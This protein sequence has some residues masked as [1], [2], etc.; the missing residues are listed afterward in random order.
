MKRLQRLFAVVV[1]MALALSMAISVSAEGE[2]NGK[3]TVTGATEGQVYTLYQIATLES[4]TAINYSYKITD[5][6]WEAFLEQDPYN[7]EVTNG[8]IRYDGQS[9]ANSELPGFALAA[10]EYAKANGIAATAS[11]TANSDSVVFENLA[12][13]YYAVDSSLGTICMLTTANPEI[14]IGDKNATTTVNKFVKEDSNGTYDKSNDASIGQ[15]VEFLI[16][17]DVALGAINYVI[18]DEMSDGLTC[19]TVSKI[20]YILNETEHLV[21]YEIVYATEGA[22]AV[23]EALNSFFGEG[24]YDAAKFEN[25]DFVL[26]LDNADLVPG[27]QIEIIYTATVNE[28]A[29]IAGTGN[30]N[31]VTLYYGENPYVES[32]KSTTTTF[33]W[34]F[35]VFKYAAAT[36][37]ELPLEGAVFQLYDSHDNVKHTLSFVEVGTH[38]TTGY[39]VYRV[40]INPVEGDGSFTDI[41]TTADGRFH[42]VGLDSGVYYLTEIAPPEG[43]NPLTHDVT[44]N[45][46]R[47]GSLSQ[48][49]SL[50]YTVVNSVDG[51][52]KVLNNTGYVL[53]GTGGTGT[54]IFI[55]V[56]GFLAIAM[57]ILLVDKKR[58][59]K[60]TF[61]K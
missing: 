31:D 32:E 52:I 2:N 36:G 19:G 44:V 59:S 12:L 41:T 24:N 7:V 47:T 26:K 45:I 33:V 53:P 60:V 8:Y 56:G 30:P 51:Y 3:I 9:I 4:S 39:P 16:E 21:D 48:T 49:A 29:V 10:V 23:A 57:G 1:V 6:K 20:S 15:E 54:I 5:E 11:V 14:S 35:A 28:N 22:D 55:A 58:M 61:V 27:T 25:A 50:N 40:V 17:V 42:I 46:M 38:D 18:K 13:G 34:D 37:E 43:Y